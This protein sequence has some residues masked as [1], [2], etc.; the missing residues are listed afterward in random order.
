LA[1]II[2]IGFLFGIESQILEHDDVAF[3]HIGDR[4]FD[5][6]ADAIIK[7]GHRLIE[8]LAQPGGDIIQI[9]LRVPA[10]GPT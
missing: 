7:L 10:F 2:I 8:Q 6:L 1:K 5:R 3:L 9:K 4:L